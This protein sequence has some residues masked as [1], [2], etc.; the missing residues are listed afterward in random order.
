MRSGDPRVV[1]AELHFMLDGEQGMR[2][3]KKQGGK[4]RT[5]QEGKVGHPSTEQHSLRLY[6]V[7]SPHERNIP[8]EIHI[9]SLHFGRYGCLIA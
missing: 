6:K 9:T 1:S 8:L 3:E 2:K 7:V 4:A 5:A